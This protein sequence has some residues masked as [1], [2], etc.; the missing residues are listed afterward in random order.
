MAAALPPQ[1]ENAPGTAARNQ[2]AAGTGSRRAAAAAPAAPRPGLDPAPLM[3]CGAPPRGQAYWLRSSDGVR[4]RIGYWPGSA[5]HVLI[6]PGRTE[7]I[8]KYGL[9]VADLARAGWGAVVLDW[10]GQGL[11][12]RLAPDPLLGHVRDFAEYQLDLSAARDAGMALGCGPMPVL[13]H[14]MGGCILLRALVDGWRPPAVSLCA[15]MLGL[16][17]NA[18]LRAGVA[19][20]AR[21]SRPLGRNLAYVPGTGPEFGLRSTPFDLNDLTR[22]AAQFARMQAQLV[23]EPALAL[24]GPSLSWIG[25][26]L[27]EMAD[28]LRSPAP[29]VPALIGIAGN[30]RIVSNEAIRARASG[31]PGAELAEYPGAEH[32]LLME[33]PDV[34]VDFLDR[35]LGLFGKNAHTA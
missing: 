30:D 2:T 5:G 31:W 27:A 9:V 11:S 34:R 16:A 22:D 1:P 20:M 29:D 10:R 6:L 13:A 25:A 28:L 4:V 33:R 17:Q 18:A 26:A 19:A 14:S 12:D 8:E 3:A 23:A 7:Y 35:I 32:E 24:G 21:L 15:P